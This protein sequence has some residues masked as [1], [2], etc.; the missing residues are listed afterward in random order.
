MR[1][2]A[3]TPHPRSRLL[4]G[5]R[6]PAGSGRLVPA[7]LPLALGGPGR[8]SGRQREPAS[9]PCVSPAPAR[10]PEPRPRRLP[11]SQSHTS[12]PSGQDHK[13]LVLSQVSPGHGSR[14]L[15][16]RHP[17]PTAP[18]RPWDLLLRLPGQPG[19]SR[20]PWGWFQ[21]TQ[22]SGRKWKPATLQA[23]ASSP[24]SPRKT[25][26]NLHPG[27]PAV[28]VSL[29]QAGGAHSPRPPTGC[30][31]LPRSPRSCGRGVAGFCVRFAACFHVSCSP[32]SGGFSLLCCSWG[33]SRILQ[34]Q[35]QG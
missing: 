16:T 26:R 15:G 7:K 34:Q 32:V 22:P 33:T 19:I 13:R 21:G 35:L 23:P 18:Q 30:P 17:R 6:R 3:R 14:L 9:P 12:L 5:G 25:N 20:E 1:P 4:E 2:G 10:P 27:R 29:A 8:R 31:L 11:P 28:S 24:T